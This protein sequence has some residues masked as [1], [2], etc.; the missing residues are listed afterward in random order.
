[1]DKKLVSILGGTGL[2]AL[3]WLGGSFYV[4]Q[5]TAGEIKATVHKAASGCSLRI[6]HIQHQQ[7]LFSSAGQFELHVGDQCNVDKDL[8]D[9]LVARVDYKTNSLILPNALTRFDWTLKQLPNEADNTDSLFELSGEGI[10][11]LT[12]AVFSTIKSQAFSG[13]F[14]EGSW[15]MEPLEGDIESYDNSMLFNLRT[16]RLVGRGGGDAIDI[17]GIGLHADLSDTTL[18]IGKTDFTIDKISTSQGFGQGFSITSVTTQNTDRLDSQVVYAL[19]A[20]NAMG[21]DGQDLNLELDINGIHAPSIKTLMELSEDA[22]SIQNLTVEEDQKLRSAI[23]ELINQG[24]T[25]SLAKLA[26]TVKSA[27]DTSSI[28]GNLKIV[29]NPN[30]AKDQ[31]IQL[32]KVLESSGQ[33]LF[34]GNVLGEEQKIQLTQMGTAVLTPEGLKASY[35]YSAGILKTNERVFEQQDVSAALL[36][37]DNYINEFLNKPIKD[38]IAGTSFEE[39]A[40]E[41]ETLDYS[42]VDTPEQLV[43]MTINGFP[44]IA[45]DDSMLEDS[46]GNRVYFQTNS[47]V[48]HQIVNTCNEGSLCLVTGM[49]DIA[50]EYHYLKQ[51]QS[52]MLAPGAAAAV[53]PEVAPAT[54]DIPALVQVSVQPSFDCNKAST[55][56]EKLICSSSDLAT[57]DVQLSQLYKQLVVNSPAAEA[58]IEDQNVWLKSVRG[59]C[60]DVE[61]LKLAYQLRIQQLAR[62]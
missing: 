9:L 33:V 59:F 51:L 19:N 62:Y 35:E 49:V 1:M 18:S 29:I 53:Q 2:V 41:A 22:S 13:Y 17:Q 58:I 43:N 38:S 34:K 46:N 23:R 45:P 44:T 20:F 11:R 5:Q 47:A 27:A 16:P 21:Y 24:L 10:T 54:A 55:N 42:S 3:A 31:A 32:A 4:N 48:G 26:G 56:V 39:S 14:D 60:A 15:R 6:Q 12:G 8:R 7:F 50:K 37:F 30:S 61:C 52:V 36:S 57:V 40:D 28:E 25:V